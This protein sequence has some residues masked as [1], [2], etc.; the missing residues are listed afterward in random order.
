[1]FYN[2]PHIGSSH[3][4]STHRY[5][6]NSDLYNPDV[7]IN[8]LI[9]ALTSTPF[10]DFRLCISLLDDRSFISANADEPDPL[11]ALLPQL[12]ELYTLLQQCRFPAFWKLYYSDDYSTLRENYTV[13]CIGFEDAVRQVVIK[14]V[15]AAFTRI[16]SER[17]GSYFHLDGAH[18]FKFCYSMPSFSVCVCVFL[19]GADFESYISKLG[20]SLESGVVNIP[21]NMDNQIEST[22]VHENITLPRKN[23]CLPG[24][25]SSNSPDVIRACQNN[26]ACGKRYLDFVYQT[27]STDHA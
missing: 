12:D 6:F 25:L 22:V 1:V 23:F 13:E 26:L 18:F 10:P 24:P 3:S 9:K 17:L 16:G 11:P 15:K 21:P 8:I 27:R 19:P 14:A 20:W 2:P 5:Q 7:V 4:R